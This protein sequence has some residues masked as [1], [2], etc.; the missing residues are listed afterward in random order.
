MEGENFY[1]FVLRG[2]KQGKSI[3][4]I[5][6]DLGKTKQALNYY[7]S[8]L[9]RSGCIKKLGYGVWEFIKDYDPKQVKKSIV[10]GRNNRGGIFTSLEPDMVR[11][12][13]F[14]I[15]FQVKPGLRNWDNREDILKRL[16]IKFKT[17]F[18]GGIKRG[19][20]FKFRG[21]NVDL[22][23]KSIIFTFSESYIGDDAA[24]VRKDLIYDVLKLIKGL[25]SKLKADF[26]INGQ[27]LF[28]VSRQHYALVKN[29]L[30][31]QYDKE[32]QRLAVYSHK[33]LWFIIDNSFNLHE[34]ETLHK[35]SAV[36]DNLK[37]QNFFNYVKETPVGHFKLMDAK[38][39]ALTQI[40]DK[41]GDN[42][43]KLTKIVYDLKEGK[44][45]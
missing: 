13:A 22:T 17:Y 33:G 23:R 11:G 27:Y 2:I 6:E 7:V 28:K 39:G 32:R 43:I 19:Q 3:T 9:K 30:A 36:E 5:A 12:H 20:S 26:Q 37:V 45:L 1:F 34:A 31:K 42:L 8:T 40:V 10:I 21:Y 15:K 25:E 29:A 41:M 18:V 38:Q 24:Q 4:Q 14:L 16:G 35:D 44:D